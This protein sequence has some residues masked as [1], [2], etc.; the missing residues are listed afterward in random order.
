M[1]NDMDIVTVDYHMVSDTAM[2]RRDARNGKVEP[3]TVTVVENKPP[4]GILALAL[5]SLGAMGFVA[6]T[7]EM[8]RITVPGPIHEAQT[9]SITNPNSL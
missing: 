2:A 3:V 6:W 5:I 9:Y 7:V 4:M 8:V 1:R